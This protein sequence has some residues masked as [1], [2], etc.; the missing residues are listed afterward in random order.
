MK[1]PNASDAFVDIEKLRGYCLNLEHPRGKH[2]ARVFESALGLTS[3]D[4]ERL[5]RKLLEAAQAEEAVHQRT[6]VYGKRYT[7]DFEVTGPAARATV[8]SAWIIRHGENYPR[9]ITC[10]VL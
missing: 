2:K 9:L 10:Y 8:R 7:L 6:D 4:A 1:L 5:Q 3:Q